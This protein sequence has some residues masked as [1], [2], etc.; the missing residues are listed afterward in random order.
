MRDI[1]FN[2]V[3]ILKE[4]INIPDGT[5]DKKDCTAYCDAYE[6]KIAQYGGIDFQLLGIGRTGHI[7]F[8]EP[9]SSLESKTRIINLDKKTRYEFIR[10]AL[11]LTNYL[12]PSRLDASSSFM[13]LESVPRYAITMGV[14][15]VM[16]AKRIA[17]MGFTESKAPII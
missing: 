3:D 5:I 8:N 14:S 15:T 13:G 10:P 6:K 16:R 7:G 4:N 12:S 17:I 11:P 2:H 1:L 9:G